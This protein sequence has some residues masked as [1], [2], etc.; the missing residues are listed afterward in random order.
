MCAILGSDLS[1]QTLRSRE[2]YTKQKIIDP[3]WP[4]SIAVGRLRRVF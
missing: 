2:P 4:T 1:G 3:W